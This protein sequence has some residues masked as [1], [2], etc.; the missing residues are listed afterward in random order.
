ME[1][2]LLVTPDYCAAAI[3]GEVDATTTPSSG[4]LADGSAS[5]SGVIS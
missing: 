5:A 1:W 2:N 3:T 4:W